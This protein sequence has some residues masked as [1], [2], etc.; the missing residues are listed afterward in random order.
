MIPRVLEPEVMDSAREAAD[1]DAMDHREVNR[2]FVDD[3]LALWGR[4]ATAAARIL[5]LGTGTAQIPLELCRRSSGAKVIA[6]DAAWHMLELAKKNVRAAGL[7][8]RILLERVDAKRL[9]YSDGQFDAVISNSIVHHIPEPAT[10]LAEAVRVLKPGGAILFRDLMRP[11]SPAELER[12][13]EMYAAGA[14]GH[15]QHMFAASLHAALSVEDVRAMVAALGFA[16]ETVQATSDRHWT[17]AAR[18]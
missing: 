6:V 16:A 12:L 9:P 14:N 17:W 1:Y 10:V 18:C 15:Q 4:D 7:E 11:E 3:F 5:D 13:V 2:R 8:E